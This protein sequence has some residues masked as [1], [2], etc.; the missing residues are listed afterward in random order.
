MISASAAIPTSSVPASATACSARRRYF[1]AG[2]MRRCNIRVFPSPRLLERLADGEVHAEVPR[3]GLAVDEEARDAIQLE[4]D[5]NA[6]RPDRREVAKSG[7][8]VVLQIAELQ[9]P[10]VVPHVAGV[11]E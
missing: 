3:F 9:I 4:P 11:G 5:V 1:L 6:D 10:R 8:G 7:T 2:A